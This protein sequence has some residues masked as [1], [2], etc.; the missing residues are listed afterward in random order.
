MAPA[1]HHHH[2]GE[3][4]EHQHCHH[5]AELTDTPQLETQ[6]PEHKDFCDLCAKVLSFG[7]LDQ[8][9]ASAAGELVAERFGESPR[10]VPPGPPGRHGAARAPPLA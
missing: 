8:P 9:L 10:V 2:H 5:G 1:L 6:E 4:S 7:S 3:E